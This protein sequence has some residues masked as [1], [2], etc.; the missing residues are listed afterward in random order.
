MLFLMYEKGKGKKSKWSPWMNAMPQT[1]PA[2]LCAS[3]KR[4]GDGDGDGDGSEDEDEENETLIEMRQDMRDMYDDM[5]PA[6]SDAFPAVFR[7]AYS[8]VWRRTHT[9]IV[10]TYVH[11][12]I[13]SHI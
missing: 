1:L 9:C 8:H 2:L 6:L 4:D 5:F 11:T 3:D 12:Y 13:Y 7:C 10:H